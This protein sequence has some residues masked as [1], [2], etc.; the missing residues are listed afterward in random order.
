MLGEKYVYHGM[1]IT[2][3]VYEKIRST[4]EL[5]AESEQVSFEKVF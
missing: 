4:V 3:D 5:L 2:M 1:D